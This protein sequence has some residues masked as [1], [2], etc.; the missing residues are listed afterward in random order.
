MLL[1]LDEYLL[2]EVKKFLELPELLA[3]RLTCKRGMRESYREFK[4]VSVFLQQAIHHQAPLAEVQALLEL[5]ALRTPA[6]LTH[7]VSL[8]TGLERVTAYR[9]LKEV[10]F[11]HFGTLFFEIDWRRILE[12]DA[13]W[14]VEYWSQHIPEEKLRSFVMGI[15]IEQLGPFQAYVKSTDQMKD[16]LNTQMGGALSLDFSQLLITEATVK[17]STEERLRN[18]ILPMLVLSSS[19]YRDHF[20]CSTRAWESIPVKEQEEIYTP[21]TFVY[22]VMRISQHQGSKKLETS[23]FDYLMNYPIKQHEQ[24]N[25]FL[26]SL[27]SV[28]HTSPAH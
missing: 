21:L 1:S 26:R 14:C 10:I 25:L 8:V 23:F 7:L 6:I 17:T 16:Y 27:K 24:Q 4:F 28:I 11:K 5:P 18:Y 13:S 2:H 12:A 3:L 15:I 20:R 22:L 9:P 19:M